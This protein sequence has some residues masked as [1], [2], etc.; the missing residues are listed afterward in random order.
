MKNI[1]NKIFLKRYTAGDPQKRQ[2][3]AAL[4]YILMSLV[5]IALAITPT[6]P[7]P[8]E[9]IYL[10]GMALVCLLILLVIRSGRDEAA[11]IG[12]IAFL[13]AALA[14]LVISRNTSEYT[15]VYNFLAD[16]YQLAFLEA[17]IL[18]ITLMI[19][20]RTTHAI[21][22]TA[23]ASVSILY[24]FFFLT[25]PGYAV[26]GEPVPWADLLIP[27]F[28]ILFSG[29]IVIS[30][31]KRRSRLL[32]RVSEE[33]RKSE[34]KAAALGRIVSDLQKDFDT[35]NRLVVSAEQ[36]T[37]AT[38][39][40]RS[41]FQDMHSEMTNLMSSSAKLLDTGKQVNS[42]SN[43]ASSASENQSAIVEET[44]A[45]VTEMSNA[46][47]SISGI[48]SR[49]KDNLEQL[50]R[51]TGNTEQ[52][53]KASSESMTNLKELVSSLEDVNGVIGK[54]SAQTGL[55]AMNA[56]IEAA[57]A[58][59]AGKGFAVV[60]DEVR[61]LSENTSVNAK[62]ISGILKD[63]SLSIEDAVR[64]NQSVANSFHSIKDEIQSV[65]MGIDEIL[66]GISELAA[67]TS[68]I[69]EG[70]VQSLTATTE[71][72]TGITSVSS[73]VDEIYG[74]INI[75]K[76]AVETVLNS[77]EQALD[78]VDALGHTG[79]EIR[80]VGELNARNLKSLSKRRQNSDRESSELSA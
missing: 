8:S 70:T 13:S 72:K 21:V 31:N 9:Q 25:M 14:M 42:S 29:V 59:N 73:M 51:N 5:I 7:N 33:A 22:G 54:I 49:R 39:S 67:G 56:A 12:T 62:S 61:K 4:V 50:T 80:E 65:V 28:L 10:L 66:K 55:L 79:A 26:T 2:Q 76:T 41:M 48:A 46:I 35:G 74:K 52:I 44:S 47:E 17:F 15:E 45:A 11:G 19:T 24:Y 36:L 20:T 43:E 1:I 18:F 57:H 68:Q 69:N 77:V 71:V 38:D 32:D 23:I 3:M 75:Q 58:G 60:A 6:V 30:S 53:L 63:I 78:K 34:E 16:I 64:Q 37:G 40:L 27:L